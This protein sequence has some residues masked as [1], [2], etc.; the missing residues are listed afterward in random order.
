MDRR[1]FISGAVVGAVGAGLAGSGTVLAA[2]QWASGS[3]PSVA[4]PQPASKARQSFAQMGE[5]IVLFH[6]LR[7]WMKVPSPLYLDIGAAD[8][9]ESSNTYLLYCTGGRGVLVE[10]NPDYVVKLRRVRP[11]DIV[12]QAGIGITDANA[13]DYYVMRGQPT[14]NTFSPAQVEM[15]RRSGHPD[16]VEKVVKMPLIAVNHVIAQCLGK[17]P[18]LLSIDVEGLD[19]DILRTLDFVA[20]KPGAVIA[21]TIMMGGGAADNTEIGVFLKSKGYVVRGGSLYNTIFADPS[22]Y[23]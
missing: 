1:S 22:R 13:A 4:D 8:P 20:F 9:V 11:E 2:R 17:A 16:I 15:Y 21:E 6:L 10:P 14:L 7:D 12:V 18:D 19:L 3:L 5:D 23:R